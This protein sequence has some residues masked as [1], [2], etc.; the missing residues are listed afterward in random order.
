MVASTD[1]VDSES[2]IFLIRGDFLKKLPSNGTGHHLVTH[3][4]KGRASDTEI[5]NYS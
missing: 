2:N 1:S 3:G 4:E 5:K